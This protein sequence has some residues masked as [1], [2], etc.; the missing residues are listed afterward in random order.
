ML[1]R[2]CNRPENALNMRK[3]SGKVQRCGPLVEGKEGLDVQKRVWQE[4]AKKLDE[5]EPGIINVLG[6]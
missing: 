6:T 1:V 5:I 3:S 2:E 4:L